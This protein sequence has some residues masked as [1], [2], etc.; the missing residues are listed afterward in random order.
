MLQTDRNKGAY[1]AYCL[2]GDDGRPKTFYV[3]RIL[4][5]LFLEGRDGYEFSQLHVN[6]KDLDKKN[7]TLENLEW[8][9]PFENV[10]HGFVNS[11]GLG[12]VPIIELWRLLQ[13]HGKAAQ[14]IIEEAMT[15]LRNL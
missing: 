3:H 13:K 10:A 2:I 6:H 14:P 8:V 7:N 9:T 1:H 5:E 12:W 4:G 15:K 11:V